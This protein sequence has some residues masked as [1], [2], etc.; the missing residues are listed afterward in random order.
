MSTEAPVVFVGRSGELAALS[1][2]LES[3]RN[4]EPRVVFIEAESGMGKTSLV[5]QFVATSDD[6][7]VCRATGDESEISLEY[8]VVAQLASEMD[9]ASVGRLPL[10]ASGPPPSADPFS[11]G[12]ELL[13]AFGLMEE[14]GP[15]LVIV[16]DDLQWADT[17]SARA[18]LF[19][20]RRLGHDRVLVVVSARPGATHI[21]GESW[22]RFLR[23]ESR[24][25]RLQLAGLETDEIQELATALGMERLPT[26][27]ADRLGEHTGGHPLYL[28]ALFEE[29]PRDALMGGVDSLPA[30][31]SLALTVVSR[32]AVLSDGTQRLVGAAAVLGQR[33]PLRLAVALAELGDD[34][35]GLEEAMDARLLERSPRMS[36]EEVSFVHPLL[37]AAVYA[38]LSPTR[39]QDLHRKAAHLVSGSASLSHRVAATTQYDDEL[40]G[41]LERT[42]Q[43]E[44]AQD[45]TSAA[46]DHLLMA[47]D[48][49]SGDTAREA[50]FLA[51]IHVMILGGND[52]R[53]ETMRD[54]VEKCA[55][56]P[57][58]SYALGALELHSG[59]IPE[60][61]ARFMEALEAAPV[62][63]HVSFR[64]R[65]A[66]SLSLICLARAD[67]EAASRWARYALDHADGD[68]PVAAFALSSLAG[69]L[70][71]VGDLAG[72]LAS[73][74]PPSPELAKPPTFE[75]NKLSARGRLRLWAN[76]LQGAV[77]DLSAALRWSRSGTPLRRLASVYATLAN[78]Q[79]RIGLWDQAVVNAEVAVSLAQ[80]ME[81]ILDLP[82]VH[83]VAS[84]L[85]AGL[86]DWEL[87]EAHAQE[88]RIHS[89]LV[90]SPW[91]T[92]YVAQAEATLARTRGDFQSA[93]DALVPLLDDPLRTF[94]DRLGVV[95]WRILH[96]EAL[97]GLGRLEEA[98][99]VI[100][101]LEGSAFVRDPPAAR[102][103]ALRLR[104]AIEDAKGNGER[105]ESVLAAGDSLAAQHEL[106]F[107]RALLET[108][109]SQVLRRTGRR[110]EA[111]SHLRSA[112][113]R[114]AT[115]RA[116]PFVDACDA[117]LAALGV[118]S[119][120][121]SSVGG[122]SLTPR[123][124]SVA[125]LVTSGMSNPEVAAELY[126]S[127]K[128]VEY[129]LGN[130][131]SKLNISSRRQ[132]QGALADIQA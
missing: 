110:R 83:A 5:R 64:G 124:Q 52:T 132:L 48:L 99:Q 130:I 123:E 112:R 60:A 79:Y 19:A 44:A 81:W 84:Y 3:A 53:A 104:G 14:R 127:T 69:A 6:V 20:L 11:V 118:H 23:D 105:A 109:Y 106:P 66:L 61:E 87:S 56:G 65:A 51:A 37:R 15:V 93:L 101:E 122:V 103:E 39:R 74:D 70:A 111:I 10:L 21:L 46:S 126:V 57:A 75:A 80:D 107:G 119:G 89:Q 38:D 29:L 96:A 22:Q 9:D 94:L 73:L 71:T 125:H 88:A 35:N 114:F 62:R 2:A 117:E 36:G 63:S 49:T 55:D 108:T 50:R 102:L 45:L 121:L 54:A 34:T 68:V 12:G 85:N 129:H 82:M 47:A 43:A 131:F 31:R 40:A 8:G 72:G 113:E 4:L 42:A 26:P 97:L 98:E 13:Q 59:R 7:A 95:P 67:G 90:P 128:T 91:S 1:A 25:S 24:V 27:G 115:M 30:P 77:E 76:D 100:T 28:R 33:C 58:K 116:R 92:L 78:A 120:E 16:L 41:E 32:L 18:L 17:A 86:G